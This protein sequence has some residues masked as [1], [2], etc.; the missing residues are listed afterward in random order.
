MK[1]STTLTRSDGKTVLL[2]ADE[3]IEIDIKAGNRSIA[4][5]TVREGDNGPTVY[6]KNGSE[7]KI[8]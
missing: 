4:R 6:D 5:L 1:Y 8:N 2:A 7:I 3:W